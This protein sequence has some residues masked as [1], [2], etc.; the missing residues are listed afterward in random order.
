M[1]RFVW[2]ADDME[3]SKRISRRDCLRHARNDSCACHCVNECGS[4]VRTVGIEKCGFKDV[5]AIQLPRTAVVRAMVR[6][7][8]SISLSVHK[9]P[10]VVGVVGLAMQAFSEASQFAQIACF[11]QCR[12]TD[13]RQSAS[14]LG[15]LW[16]CPC[17]DR[18]GPSV[19]YGR[20]C[21]LGCVRY[22]PSPG[23]IAV[24]LDD[25]LVFGAFAL[26]DAA[27]FLAQ[28]RAH[29]L[30]VIRRVEVDQIFTCHF[31]SPSLIDAQLAHRIAI[32]MRSHGTPRFRARFVH[33][34]C[35]SRTPQLDCRRVEPTLARTYARLPE[36]RRHHMQP[37]ATIQARNAGKL[38]AQ[39]PALSFL[40]SC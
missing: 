7:P 26:T 2:I 20:K 35:S 14:M 10:H 40:R 12:I 39:I 22:S 24:A 5:G 36:P 6:E 1:L 25:A 29:K 31:A 27:G 3:P 11:R 21:K 34:S 19:R 18:R 38:A 28:W 23:P 15:K 30:V 4:R 13:V 33:A 37:A 9:L 17:L 8:W 16:R 32:A